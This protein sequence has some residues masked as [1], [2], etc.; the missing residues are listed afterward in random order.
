MRFERRRER[1]PHIARGRSRA[2]LLRI[3]FAPFTGCD[4]KIRD[5]CGRPAS[6]ANRTRKRR[7]G[8]E[9]D[10]VKYRT[11]IDRWR[12][13]EGRR[14]RRCDTRSIWENFAL[15]NERRRFRHSSVIRRSRPTFQPRI[16]DTFLNRVC[17]KQG[18]G[19]LRRAGCV[20][21]STSLAHLLPAVF[22]AARKRRYL[23]R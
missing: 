13:V 11:R 22:C 2:A 3:D 15:E 6:R 16:A 8:C 1:V 17:R 14:H 10:L 21:E 20:L 5:R 9:E 12:R 4:P 7:T 19:L 18:R 23:Q